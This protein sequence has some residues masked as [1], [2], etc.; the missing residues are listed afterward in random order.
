[1]EKNK[2][3]KIIF[4]LPENVTLAKIIITILKNNGLEENNRD[5]LKKSIEGKETC[6]IIVRDAVLAMAQNKAP[7][8]RLTEILSNHLET[9]KETAKKII[10]DI[11]EQLIPYAKIIN[12]DEVGSIKEEEKSFQERLLD[13]IRSGQKSIKENEGEQPESYLK[14]PS[15]ADVEKNAEK[16]KNEKEP[17]PPINKT[18]QVASQTSKPD[19]YKEPIE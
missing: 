9:S 16:M 17:I 1:M 12:M 11:K 8:E 7:E 3:K 19:P 5:Y 13:K 6:L 4:D 14:K 2:N 15:V 18:P 10:L